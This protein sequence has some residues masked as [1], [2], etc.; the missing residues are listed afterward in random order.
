M[1][2]NKTTSWGDI[3]V[4][5]NR[6]TYSLS[7]KE[8]DDEVRDTRIFVNELFKNYARES[9]FLGQLIVQDKIDINAAKKI[10]VYG[11]QALQ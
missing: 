6:K 4:Y 3:S 11:L 8:L 1:P 5:K 2:K 10:K 9:R 7:K